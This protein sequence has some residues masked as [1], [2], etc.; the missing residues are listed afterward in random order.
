MC[1]EI[2]THML[3]WAIVCPISWAQRLS[4]NNRMIH[5]HVR[6]NKLV[7]QQVKNISRWMHISKAW[8]NKKIFP[9]CRKDIKLKASWAPFQECSTTTEKDL[10]LEAG[11]TKTKASEEDLVA[12]AHQTLRTHAMCIWS[13]WHLPKNSTFPELQIPALVRSYNSQD[14]L[15]EVCALSLLWTSFKYTLCICLKES[16]AGQW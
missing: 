8:A 3:M 15:G 10:P 13:A 11:G 12:D 6:Q 14:R 2:L 1:M 16:N 9:W 5:S 4:G 7:P